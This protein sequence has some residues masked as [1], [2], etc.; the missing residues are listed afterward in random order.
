MTPR[1]RALLRG[2]DLKPQTEDEAAIKAA[3]KGGGGELIEI[4]LSGE[5]SG[6][7][8]GTKPGTYNADETV[9]GRPVYAALKAGK[10]VWIVDGDG[11]HWAIDLWNTEADLLNISWHDNNFLYFAYFKDSDE[12]PDAKD[13]QPIITPLSIKLPRLSNG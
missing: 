11:D 6:I 3:V 2:R 9:D 4:D 13:K 12:D 10:P 8:P 1:E 5:Q 7:T